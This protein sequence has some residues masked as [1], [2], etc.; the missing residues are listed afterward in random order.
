MDAVITMDVLFLDRS[1]KKSNSQ[2][3]RLGYHGTFSLVSCFPAYEHTRAALR[4]RST[5]ERRKRKWQ[6]LKKLLQS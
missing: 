5:R 3:M 1:L 2:I 4:E 6:V